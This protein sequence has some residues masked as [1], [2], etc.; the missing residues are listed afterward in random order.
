[1]AESNH[2]TWAEKANET[3]VKMGQEILRTLIVI[4]GGATIAMLSFI[5]STVGSGK[6]SGAGAALLSEPL[7]KFGWGIVITIAAMVGAYCTD[8]LVTGHAFQMG[9]AETD[10]SDATSARVAIYAT[11]KGVAHTLT[12]LLTLASLGAF[13]CGMCELKS[14]MAEALNPTHNVA[15]PI[16]NPKTPPAPRQQLPGS[17]PPGSCRGMRSLI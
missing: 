13:A 1:M 2:R 14:H 10:P 4:H 3:A 9:N 6:L 11:A 7:M 15:K 5:G 17:I 12:V 16:S 8:Y